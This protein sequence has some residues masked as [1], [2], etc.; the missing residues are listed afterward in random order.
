MEGFWARALFDYKAVEGTELSVDRLDYVYVEEQN[1]S[2]WC[3][4][5][6]WGT[7]LSGWLPTDYVEKCDPPPGA[8]A[9]NEAPAQ[10]EPQEPVEY[11]E[12]Q[13]DLPPEPEPEPEPQPVVLEPEPEPEPEPVVIPEPAPVPMAPPEPEPEP[14][15]EPI[16]E[17]IPE[18]EP[19]PIP[20]PIPEPK[21]VVKPVAKSE[22]AKPAASS[23]SS[24]SSRPIAASYSQKPA[25][26]SY[27]DDAASSVQ[28][29]SMA[30]GGGAGGAGAARK[31]AGGQPAGDAKTC[32]KCGQ[33]INS[34]FVVAKDKSF[35]ADC[36]RCVQCKVTLGG[37]AFIEKDGSHYCEN[38]YYTAYNP[39]CGRCNEVIKGQYISAL[40][41]AWHPDHFVCT[42]CG[43]PFEGNQFHKHDNKPYCEYHFNQKFAETCAKCGQRIEGQVFEALDR[44]YHLDCF[45]CSVN[46]HKIGEGVNFHVY[47]D[48]VYCPQHFEEL[49]LQRCAGCNT[50]IKGQYVKVLDQHFH[51]QCWKCSDC[52]TVIS[53][54]N[55]GQS[56][57][58]FYCRSCVS[59][60]SGGAGGGGASVG[61][62][63]SSSSGA[64]RAPAASVAS[65]AA[66]PREEKPSVS[67][68]PAA[69][70]SEAPSSSGSP[71]QFMS[72]DQLK[73]T[74]S[75]PPG[76]DRDNRERYL[77]DD[78]FQK[79][80][81][82]DKATFDG[83]P[84][85]KKKRMKSKLG[86]F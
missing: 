63:V 14:E 41:Q 48:K 66:K 56:G 60:R 70:R 44:K 59:K 35:H 84:P 47:D 68:A 61:S 9:Q 82:M 8:D 53:S 22:P 21:P 52:G 16:P 5:K 1:D 11:F 55:C 32:I 43:K 78:D 71:G 51:P 31:P 2:G 17:A 46:D 20:E 12:Q 73:D 26:S 4:A 37:K 24:N 3:L 72:Y 15:P 36:F 69:A 29:L 76:I 23:Y 19:E 75:L 39:R 58:K 65:S 27:G 77:S 28:R 49:F 83:L 30:S 7:D 25:S 13:P 10:Q 40:G 62:S 50:I 85:W 57:G 74:N 33:S 80:F 18:P 64:S 34:A 38:C 81:Q 54:D 86:L 79:L 45:T 67:A 42:E 6:K